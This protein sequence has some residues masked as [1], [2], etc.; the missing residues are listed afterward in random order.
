[1]NE[2]QT[3]EQI[4]KLQSQINDLTAAFYKNNFSTRQDF[5]KD[6]AFNSSLKV[7]VYTTL[8]SCEV[9]QVGVYNGDL[10]VCSAA[11]TWTIV[12]TQS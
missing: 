4:A 11:D 1:M 5:N 7:P 12:G 10:M 9:G 2:N 6:S 8:P 3:Q